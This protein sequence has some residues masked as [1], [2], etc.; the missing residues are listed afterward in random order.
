[1]SVT[2]FIGNGF[3]LHLGLKTRFIDV[4]NEYIKQSSNTS[5]IQKFKR[6]LE[7]DAPNYTNWSDFEMGMAQYAQNVK[8]SSE[9]IGCV[10]DFRDF[11]R[12]FLKEQNNNWLKKL[13]YV[14]EDSTFSE[15]DKSI[16]SFYSVP[17]RNVVRKIDSI[18]NKERNFSVNVISFNYTNTIDSL[19]SKGFSSENISKY[20][21]LNPLHIHGDLDSDVILGVD[22]EEQMKQSGFTI[23]KKVKRAFIKPL[24]NFEFDQQ[25]VEQAKEYIKSSNVICT[26]GFSFGDSDLSWKMELLEWLRTSKSHH[27]INY[28]YEAMSINISSWQIDDKLNQEDDYKTTFLERLGCS[29]SEINELQEQVHIP[30]GHKIFNFK[31][32][33]N[34]EYK[35]NSTIT[36]GAPVIPTNLY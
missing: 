8:S 26:F 4:Y 7:K 9:F 16:E 17:S 30:I 13:E 19:I 14:S 6:E 15:M 28:Q 2:F 21:I 32:I 25:R 35:I 23:T 20:Y 27:L 3:D 33:I 18:V 34:K 29:E 36:V 31:E 1:M 10:H 11:M 22:N 24:L 5:Y 12:A